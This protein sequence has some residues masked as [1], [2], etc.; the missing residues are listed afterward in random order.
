MDGQTFLF[1]YEAKFKC[2][3]AGGVEVK[4]AIAP[5]AN[6]EVGDWVS[7]WVTFHG[8][9]NLQIGY[10]DSIGNED[11]ILFSYDYDAS[12][13]L[14]VIMDT[15]KYGWIDSIHA[16][17][18]I[19]YD[20]N[21][22][23]MCDAK[24][25]KDNI[26]TNILDYH[27][28]YG[29]GV[30]AETFIPR[31]L[32]LNHYLMFNTSSIG[33]TWIEFVMKN[34][35]VYTI[36]YAK[37][38]IKDVCGD[39][40]GGTTDHIVIIK[41]SEYIWCSDYSGY[42]VSLPYLFWLWWDDNKL[43]IGNG[44]YIGQSLIAVYDE[45]NDN[46]QIESILIGCDAADSDWDFYVRQ[47]HFV[48]ENKTFVPN[49]VLSFTFDYDALGIYEKNANISIISQDLDINYVLIIDFEDN[50]ECNICDMKSKIK[51]CEKC[52]YDKGGVNVAIPDYKHIKM[53]KS[54]GHEYDINLNST[55]LYLAQTVFKIKRHDNFIK[56]NK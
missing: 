1:G 54:F 44:E 22:S 47:R 11:D 37:E 56:I 6:V 33:E 32:W 31:Y 39:T 28:K 27:I 42:D 48:L 8:N 46:D 4:L 7:F 23:A 10:G 29:L 34:D 26:T 53:H 35:D 43:E 30:M 55:D 17:Q 12:V 9:N 21:N 19:F 5:L 50:T 25:I 45:F 24:V 36:E 13:N 16:S 52:R 18:W 41:N 20:Y 38:T 49:D 51:E 15:L 3:G 2:S 14:R 40:R